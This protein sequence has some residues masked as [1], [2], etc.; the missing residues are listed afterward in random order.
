MGNRQKWTPEVAHA[1]E[2]ASGL[3]CLLLPAVF[4]AGLC[5]RHGVT[6]S[7]G[8]GRKVCLFRQ[9]R[10]ERIPL[11]VGEW[12]KFLEDCPFSSFLLHFSFSPSPPASGSQLTSQWREHL[13]AVA[14]RRE[15]GIATV[16][17]FLP[18]TSLAPANKS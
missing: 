18:L 5:I 14:I 11:L 4:I 1:G 6:S 8:P 7:R 9:I 13:S 17:S 12:V 15:N 3:N 16:T 2:S 10:R